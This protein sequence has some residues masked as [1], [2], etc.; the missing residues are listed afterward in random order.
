MPRALLMIPGPS[1]ID[2]LTLLDMAQPTMSHVA[3][4]FDEMHRETQELL[5]KVFG[6]QGKV[7]VIPGSGTAGL[8]LAVRSSVRRGEKVLVLK[9]GYFGD[10]L[11]E[12]A[13][14]IGAEVDVVQS[15]LGRGFDGGRVEA[16]LDE[17]EYDVV[18]LQ[19]VE[20]SVSVANHVGEVAR[21]AKKRGIRVVVDG[22]ASVGGMEMRMDEWGVDVCIT[23]SQK[24]LA[25]PPGL[26]L[27]AYSKDFAP[28]TDNETLYF[29]ITKLLKEM[30]S[31]RNYYI[32][33][34]VNMIYAL[35]SSLKRIEREGV[36]NRFRRHR[37]LAQAVQRGVESLGLKL[38][39]EEP[40]RAHTVTAVYLPEGVEWARFYSEMRSRNVEVAGG[41]G[42]LRGRVF[43]IGHMGEVNANDVIA[44]L[45]AVERSLVKTG[46]R[47]ELGASVRAAQEILALHDY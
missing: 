36:E 38:V 44:T 30:E 29:N 41:L 32:T 43:R 45:A 27:V 12:G 42:E 37:I 15:P 13:R 4:E 8:E 3:A 21:V 40:Y 7:V 9:T 24:G 6:T 23:G 22:I 14:R 11:V 34:A 20:T 39:A 10:Y 17:K 35:Y 25:V 31:T 18:M 28:I 47:V 2:P 1:I 5:K 19:H 46:Y 16:I 26:A 33:P